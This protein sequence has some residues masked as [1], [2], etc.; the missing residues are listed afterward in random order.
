[1]LSSVLRLGKAPFSAPHCSITQPHPELA[2][3]QQINKVRK[4][5]RATPD[6]GL[7]IQ[8]FLNRP[9]QEAPDWCCGTNSTE[10]TFIT[11]WSLLNQNTSVWISLFQR[12]F[13]CWRHLPQSG[14]CICISCCVALLLIAPHLQTLQLSEC[15]YS[16]KEEKLSWS[17][18][19][20]VFC[21]THLLITVCT[22][23]G[24][25]TWVIGA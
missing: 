9:E 3:W 17:S 20:G 15:A 7:K 24:C 13:R 19:R 2:I 11:Y 4:V 22:I 16:R 21:V 6:E 8:M 23:I 25:R 18:L 5:N 1:M 14:R 12:L 10:V